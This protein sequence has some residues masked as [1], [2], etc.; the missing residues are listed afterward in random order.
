MITMGD[1]EEREKFARNLGTCSDK[2][3]IG[4][5]KK[6]QSASTCETFRCHLGFGIINTHVFREKTINKR[7]DMQQPESRT[8]LKIE[9]AQRYISSSMFVELHVFDLNRD[10][11]SVTWSSQIVF[12]LKG[13]SG[14]HV[15]ASSLISL[16]S[17]KPKEVS[18]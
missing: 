6:D 13:S 10:S 12:H 18:L 7:S 8:V 17:L 16:S 15:L 9:S 2:V 4:T 1:E 3:Q 5:C 14:E 11:P